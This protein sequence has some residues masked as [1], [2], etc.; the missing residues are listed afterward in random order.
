MGK[1]MKE[2]SHNN[3]KCKENNFAGSHMMHGFMKNKVNEEEDKFIH[4][5]KS[6][7]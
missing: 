7:D 6:H 5:W 4:F 1:F 3:P 2:Q